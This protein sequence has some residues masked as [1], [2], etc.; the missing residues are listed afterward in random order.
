MIV[1]MN[2]P[3]PQETD[4]VLDKIRQQGLTAHCLAGGDK[5]VITAV[6]EADPAFAEQLERFS[7]VERVVRVRAPFKL[8]SREFQAEN[9]IVAVGQVRFGAAAIPVVAGPCAVENYNQFR[10]AALAAK[11]AGA[12]ML[13][14]GAY[15]PRTSPYSFQGL[16]H[17]GLVILR[18]VGRETGLPVVTE[19][20]DPRTVG[21]V[22]EHVDMLQVGARNM[23]NFVLLKE[24]AQAGR[25]VLLK[26]SPAASVEEWLMAAEYLLAGGNTGVVLCERGIRTFENYTR[27]T[28]DLAAV[29]L[30]KH[31]SHL[32]VVI[33]PSHGTGNWRLV[34]AMARAAV[35]AGADGLLIEI[36]PWPEE[37]LSDG[38]QSLTLDKFRQL[39][40]ELAKVAAAVG[41]TITHGEGDQTR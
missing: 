4:R 27:N 21:L 33:D 29:P 16:E 40:S 8:A 30:V 23:Q 18:D 37:A 34:G 39:M 26:R 11:A 15:K 24:V 17:E 6:G 19:V 20:T 36:H 41:R 13:R 14:G 7:G 9:S 38:P 28:L 12:A 1:V 3:T 35:A 31:L 25:P 10:E 2:A 32:P 22:A 5:T